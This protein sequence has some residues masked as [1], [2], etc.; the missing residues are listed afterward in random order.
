[1]A[2]R[3]SPLCKRHKADRIEDKGQVKTLW[4][5]LR[6]VQ[7]KCGCTTNTLETVYTAVLPFLKRN[8]TKCKRDEDLH[9]RANA[10]VLQLHGC[11]NCHDYVYS[12]DA[13]LV[14]CPKC[15]HPRFNQKKTPNE[16][17]CYMHVIC[18]YFF[19]NVL[20]FNSLVL[21]GV[22]VFPP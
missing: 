19:G 21:A 3:D 17:S 22:L 12:P 7:R 8:T 18:A 9:K 6:E 5:V 15:D 1:M 11:V 20:T 10:V 16:V 14:N 2:G 4:Q 13:F